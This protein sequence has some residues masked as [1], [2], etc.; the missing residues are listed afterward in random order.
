M[1]AVLDWELCTVGD[2][3]ADVGLMVAY[4]SEMAAAAHGADVLFPEPVTSLPGFPDADGARGGV[5]AGLGPRPVGTRLLGRVRLLEG[6]DHRRRRLPALAQRP[7]ERLG[8]GPPAACGRA[9]RDLARE[10]A[11]AETNWSEL[12][13]GRPER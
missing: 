10:A 9:A 1:L 12:G 13:S 5:R 2:P 7:G 3:L 6:R 4:W 8:R 11:A